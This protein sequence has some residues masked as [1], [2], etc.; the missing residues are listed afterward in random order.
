M[1]GTTTSNRKASAEGFRHDALMYEGS[2]DFVAR[3][4]PF[5]RD[6]V[7]ADEPI[8]VVVSL[9]KIQM[10]RSAL[11]HDAQKVRFADM[12]DVGHNPARII[13][14]WR[15]FVNEHQGRGRPFR[16]I[17]EPISPSRVAEELVECERHEALLNVAFADGPAWWLACPYDTRSLSPPVLA[18]ARRN[19]P[20]VVD[21]ASRRPS[22]MFRDVV[23]MAEPFDR[24]LP[25]PD[26]GTD[27]LE[28]VFN[29]EDL[30]AVRALVSGFAS[31]SGADLDR[32]YDLVLAAD[33]AA[34]NSVRYGGG[35]GTV[36]VW[37]TASSVICEVSDAGHVDDPLVGRVRPA[38]DR[39]SGFGLWLANQVC[40]L[41]QVR[42]FATGT[43]VRLHMARG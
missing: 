29:I 42:A 14:A 33:E 4:S 26:P 32:T 27:P 25:E 40:D 30:R 3:V 11:A 28:M 10:L 22:E 20:F 41:V 37:R 36:R 21:H 12:A 38:P 23:E 7:N 2:G 8:L 6:A 18:E 43:V 34:T 5:I 19:H 31:A 17:G 13:P 39:G 1:R 16:G 35:R 9:D 15:E 24:P